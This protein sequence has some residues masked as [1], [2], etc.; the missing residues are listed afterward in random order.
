MIVDCFGMLVVFGFKFEVVELC[1]M[2]EDM[3][4]LI[5]V[6]FDDVNWIFV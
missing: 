4:V 3:V 5:F 2:I 6:D 1:L